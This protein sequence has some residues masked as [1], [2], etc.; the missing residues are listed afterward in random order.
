MNRLTHILAADDNTD[1]LFLLQQAF[2]KAG[3]ESHL[4][5]VS[6]GLEAQAYLAG[7][8]GYADRSA[9]PFP[10][11]VLLD[12]NMPR[13]SG[14]DVLSWVRSDRRLGSTV[15]HVLTASARECDARRAYELHAN[16]YVIK[17]TRLDELVAFVKTLHLWHGF[18]CA[19]PQPQDGCEGEVS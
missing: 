3:V 16:S 7:R 9:H 14:F 15:V 4:H 17:P 10:D 1:D 11:V 5:T 6:D 12:L 19:S 8:N 18:A 13:M 2:R